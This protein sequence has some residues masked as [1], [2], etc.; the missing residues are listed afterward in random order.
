MA[1]SIAQIEISPST[2]TYSVGQYLIYTGQ[3]YKVKAAI[4]V[5]ESLNVGTN[6]EATT[7]MAEL[8]SLIS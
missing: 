7:V 2:H 6:I 8:L 3:L 1:G 4:S 5:G